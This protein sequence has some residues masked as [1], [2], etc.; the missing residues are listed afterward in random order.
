MHQKFFVLERGRVA[1]ILQS[2]HCKHVDFLFEV[3]RELRN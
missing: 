3:L 2:K 1:K